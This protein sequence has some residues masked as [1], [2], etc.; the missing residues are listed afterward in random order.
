MID[1]QPSLCYQA[2]VIVGSF[3]ISR[4]PK[5]CIAALQKTI[6]RRIENLV[7][8]VVTELC[9]ARRP[10]DRKC[11]LFA[12]DRYVSGSEQRPRGLLKTAQIIRH[13]LRVVS[14][15]GSTWACNQ[16]QHGARSFFSVGWGKY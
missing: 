5:N 10:P 9:S 12:D 15:S 3:G 6:G 2:N 16:Y 4:K 8:K 1:R 13:L 11:D 7:V 14:G